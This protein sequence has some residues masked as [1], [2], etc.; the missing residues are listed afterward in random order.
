MLSR[1]ASPENTMRP[2]L[3]PLLCLPFALLGCPPDEPDKDDTAVAAGDAPSLSIAHAELDLGELVPE[4]VALVPDWLQDDLVVAMG[5]LNT[6]LQN[7]LAT[8]LIDL[9]DPY[10]LDEV[11][12]SIAHTS[13][14]V[15][16][17]GWFFPEIL[18]V[19]AELVYAYDPELSYVE[20]LDEGEPGTDADY[21]TTARYTVEEDGAMVEKTVDPDIYYWYVVH[22][23]LE[24]ELPW[25]IDAWTSSNPTDPD[26][27]MFWRE[28]LWDK[29]ADDCP[30]DGRACPLL[31][32]YLTVADTVWKGKAET[33][34]DNGAIGEITQYIWDAIDFGAGSERPVQP[35]R[36]YT[37][38]AGNCGEHADLSCAATRVG[39]IPCRN[40][41]ARS[42]DHTWGEFWDDRWVAFEP[43]GTHVDYFGYYGGPDA[44]YYVYDGKDN[45][46]DGVADLGESTDDQDGDG[47]TIAEGDCNDNRA[48]VNPDMI[49]VSNG[50]DD[51]CNG[52][53]DDDLDP[54]AVDWDGD[55]WTITDGDC[56]DID[57]AVNPDMVETEDG[58]DE[59]CDGVADEGTDNADNAEDSD[60]D[61]YSIAEGDCDD[62][63]PAVNPGAA[64][65]DGG[66]DDDC[67]GVA[68]EGEYGADYDG[69]GY[70]MRWGD[71]D[72]TDASIHDRA[73]DPGYR[74]GNRLYA[75]T[76]LR[77][78]TF[79][80]DTLTE[81]YGVPAWLEFQVTDAQGA[82]VDGASVTIFG[83]WAV[84]GHG[85]AWTYASETV[86]D[87]DGHAVATVGK[88][89]P[90][91]YAVYSP[92]ED[93]PGAGSLYQAVE[94]IEAYD[95]ESFEIE[96]TVPNPGALAVTEL[97]LDDSAAE[98]VLMASFEVE[99]HRIAADGGFMTR[100]YEFWYG[101]FTRTGDGGRLDWFV[102][103]EANLALFEAGEAFEALALGQGVEQAD[104]ELGLP[105]SAPHWL[106]LYNPAVSSH[107]VGSLG[108]HVSSP[109][110]AWSD[111]PPVLEERFRIP[112]R[113]WLSLALEP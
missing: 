109:S 78:D 35:S 39:L 66:Y 75:M 104:L 1:S 113:G 44:D 38:G 3:L 110:G 6:D 9:D 91:G 105:L 98:V 69:D 103:D 82:P 70:S 71:C 31:Q 102:V 111:E 42:N 55:G 19:N 72:D 84:Y 32:D 112:P 25:F 33:R 37:V 60:A 47:W 106:V 64:E 62:G 108:A 59:N 56:N 96:L 4:A 77:G 8:L 54:F 20:L 95:T 99:S 52:E 15:L 30:D 93:A 46:C 92:L 7:E 18:V 2:A 45:D 76:S 29:A 17:Y 67:D 87:L 48:E 80:D 36:I 85:D 50:Y 63:D 68:D 14:E 27:G 26:S 21:H 79:V 88:H 73:D 40:V 13:P 11:G 89:N 57:A 23:R 22:P 107:M 94:W 43:I 28:F 10:L 83:T 100:E 86:T 97:G 58:R 53:A 51:D 16:S 101:S 61:G 12:F 5:R 74:T 24:D 90:Y 34:T 65:D 81:N 49:E 41:G